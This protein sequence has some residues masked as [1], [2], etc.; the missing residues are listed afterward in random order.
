MST[1]TLDLTRAT[2]ET[3]TILIR[4]SQDTAQARVDYER[5]HFE[6]TGT[7]PPKGAWANLEAR[8]TIC[9]V[10]AQ[11]ERTALAERLAAGGVSIPASLMT[12]EH[13]ER[14]A[15]G[16]YHTDR[17]AR[18]EAARRGIAV[19]LLPVNPEPETLPAYDPLPAGCLCR[20]QLED[21]GFTLP[22]AEALDIDDLRALLASVEAL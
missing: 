19:V 18:E 11:S 16:G 20:E 2:R 8:A 12:A 13:R 14:V 21:R 7:Q 22:E 15:L 1:A 6:I 10:W 5:K 17:R 3:L 9:A 4:T